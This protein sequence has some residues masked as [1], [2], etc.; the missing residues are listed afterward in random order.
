M[1]EWIL[2]SQATLEA[3]VSVWW[4]TPLPNFLNYL[5]SVRFD[6]SH[7]KMKK[8]FSPSKWPEWPK[9][10]FFISYIL[11]FLIPF[12]HI[13]AISI[14]I[15]LQPEQV[16]TV[17]QHLSLGDWFILLQVH[18]HKWVFISIVEKLANF[19]TIITH[20]KCKWSPSD[21]RKHRHSDLLGSYCS[22][23]KVVSVW[24]DQRTWTKTGG[25]HRCVIGNQTQCESKYQINSDSV[26]PGL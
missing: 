22:S 10:S 5:P 17:T 6:C 2:R 19:K 23:C 20:N 18:K 3:T 14:Y 7:K 8:L 12:S 24:V 16:A 15:F 11:H 21:R 1:R 4:E 25:L 13:F 26:T 9:I